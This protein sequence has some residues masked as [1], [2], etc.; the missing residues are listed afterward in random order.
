MHTNQRGTR[1]LT[2]AEQIEEMKKIYQARQGISNANQQAEE[3]AEK[4]FNEICELLL[5]GGYFRA[6]VSG[7]KPFD[8]ILGGLAWAISSS[9]MDVDLDLFQENANLGEKLKLGE[10]IVS[11]LVRMKCPY[12]LQTY[13]IKGLDYDHIFPVIQWL[14]KKVIET[15]MEFGDS[16][17][18]FS[19]EQFTRLGGVLPEEQLKKFVI[20]D[21][22]KKQF[23]KQFA[24]ERRFKRSKSVK[25]TAQSTILEYTAKKDVVK[26]SEFGSFESSSGNETASVGN[27]IDFND[28]KEA[29]SQYQTVDEVAAS[30]KNQSFFEERQLNSQIAQLNKEIAQSQSV[31]DGIQA[32]YDEANAYLHELEGKLRQIDERCNRINEESDKLDAM[33]TPE[34]AVQLEKL[35]SLVA[36]NEALKKQ[37]KE[38]KQT[39]KEHMRMLKEAIE[40]KAQEA[41]GKEEEERI[42]QINATFAKDS[43]KLKKLRAL[44]AQKTRDI[45]LIQRRLDDVPSRA[46]QQQYQTMF[47]ELYEQIAAKLIDTRRQFNT[48]NT[49][50]DTRQILSKEVTILDSIFAQYKTS[51]KSRSTQQKFL[52]SMEDIV[53]QIEANCKAVFYLFGWLVGCSFV[54]SFVWLVGWL[55]DYKPLFLTTESR[56]S[57][58]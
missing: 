55:V 39:C 9:N 57:C 16:L 29:S 30:G 58:A 36:L 47:V 31:R 3:E 49:M 41:N 19:E 24:P 12:P 56:G 28:I 20:S 46:E 21:V 23:D 54:R 53:S 7:I 34:N 35:K 42:A 25:P 8:K 1:L 26:S 40:Q 48:Y 2:Q 17:R 52:S 15:R 37:E 27:Y 51:M 14:I 44:S 22:I 6:R 45:M 10:S 18:R 43:E 5:T 13:Q 50:E 38:F 11:A 4:K 32:K 33:I